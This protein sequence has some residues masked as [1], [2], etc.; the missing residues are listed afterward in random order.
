MGLFVVKRLLVPVLASA[1]VLGFGVQLAFADD[2]ARARLAYAAMER[3]FFSPRRDD[4]RDT[5]GGQVGS[6]AWPFSQALA[7]ALEVAQVT[8]PQKPAYGVL[9]QRFGLLDRRFRSGQ[10]YTAVPYGS[11]YYDDNE[12]IALDL[13]DWNNLNPHPSA[14]RAAAR[15]FAAVAAAWSYDPTFPCPGGVPWTTFPGEESRNTVSTANAAVLGLRLYQLDPQPLLLQWST[16]MLSWLDQCLLAPNGLFWDNIQPDGT[17]DQS[18]W[19]YNQGSVME[20]YRLL[21]LATGN[22]ADLTRAESVADMTLAAF[23]SRWPREPPEFAA[24]FFRRLLSLAAIDGRTNYVAAAKAYADQL[25][26]RRRH[27]LLE[28]AALVQLYATLAIPA[29]PARPE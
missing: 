27:S 18:E 19:S 11:V 14:V 26:K 20:A 1:A 6:H 8:R 2:A 16:R 10:L 7:A 28:Q 5:A 3:T 9:R 17:V 15:I 22:P 25:S 23:S 13:L 4:Y 29:P 12:W 21:Y 24:I